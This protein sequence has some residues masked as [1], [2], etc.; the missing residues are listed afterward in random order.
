MNKKE[1]IK[2]SNKLHLFGQEYEIYPEFFNQS[3]NF[4]NSGSYNE[5]IHAGIA[6]LTFFDFLTS[7]LSQ[8]EILQ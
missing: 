1:E 7:T 6:I 2:I 4:I 3:Y 8:N 5:K